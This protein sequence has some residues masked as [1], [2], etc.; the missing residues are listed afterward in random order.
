M[1]GL[2]AFLSQNAIKAENEK[3]IISD[4]FVDE[5]GK[6]IPWEIRALTAEEDEALRKSCTKKIRNKGII[7]QE[8]NYEEYMAKLIVECVVFPNLRDKELQ[9]SY[10]V[11]GADKLVKKMLTSGEYAELLE[12]VQEVNG[13][14]VGMDELVEEVK[15]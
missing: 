7:T 4:R 8:T 10:G 3:H 6:P 13:F 5:K 12:K 15:N 11:L 14:D 9:E 2:N 1:S